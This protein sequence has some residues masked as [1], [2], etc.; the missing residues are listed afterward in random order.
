VALFWK[1]DHEHDG[2][3]RNIKGMLTATEMQTA[4]VFVGTEA[5]DT[6]S[7]STKGGTLTA[8]VIT[9]FSSKLLLC[10]VSCLQKA[11]L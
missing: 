5:D 3:Y 7:G 8:C 4:F 11:N 1:L 6:L 10:G 9:G 2:Y